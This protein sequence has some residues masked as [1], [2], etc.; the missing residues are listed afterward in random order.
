MKYFQIVPLLT[1]LPIVILNEAQI[2]AAK[3]EEQLNK[4][5]KANAESNILTV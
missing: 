2:Q 3:A 5:N 4:A 1:P